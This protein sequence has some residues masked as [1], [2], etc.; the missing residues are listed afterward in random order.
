MKTITIIGITSLVAYQT[1]RVRT[2][3]KLK[4]VFNRKGLPAD[5]Q[6]LFD[7]LDLW[8]MDD[9]DSRTAG[10][11]AAQFLKEQVDA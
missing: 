4:N 6:R 8:K 9:E 1:G 3:D 10:Q 7:L 2:Y 5:A 11:I